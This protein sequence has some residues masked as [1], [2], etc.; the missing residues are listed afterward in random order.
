M[1][2]HCSSITLTHMTA[3]KLVNLIEHL[4]H[5]GVVTV[6]GDLQ[7]QAT[8]PCGDTVTL[9]IDVTDGCN[10]AQDTLTI[11]V[12]KGKL[13]IR[14]GVAYFSKNYSKNHFHCIDVR[15]SCLPTCILHPA[16]LVLHHLPSLQFIS[17]GSTPTLDNLA[18][19]ASV[20][21]SEAVA[22]GPVFTV[23]YSD[24]NTDEVTNNFLSLSI[25]SASIT[26]LF[27]LDATSG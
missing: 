10:A 3:R 24:A 15:C 9:T 19:T 12:D 16:L 5:T 26:G 21:W 25:A 14:N 17:P 27:A 7:D 8:I 6:A 22:Y 18:G 13:F 23:T 4:W 11:T 2:A 20:L 1:K